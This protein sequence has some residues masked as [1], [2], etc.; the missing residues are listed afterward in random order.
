MTVF[1]N[2]LHG[3]S[4]EQANLV[5]AQIFSAN[6]WRVI[7]EMGRK[8][9]FFLLVWLC[10]RP[11]ANKD[12]VYARCR[13]VEAAPDGYLDLWGR[14]HFKSSIITFAGI[15]QEIMRNPEI[16]VGIFSHNN[17]TARK[18][19]NQIKREFEDNRRLKMAYPEILFEKPE[20][21]S[22]RW[23]EQGGIVVRRKGNPKEATVEAHGLIDGMPV[24]A[25]YRLQVY[26][27][28][29]TQDN[30][31]TFEQMQ[32]TVEAWELSTFL[33]M[34][35]SRVWYAGTRYH[36]A[37]A[38]RTI[39]DRGAAIE[40]CHP[41][42]VDGTMAGAPVLLSAEYLAKKRRDLGP[43][44]FSA[45]MLLNPVADEKQGFLAAWLRHWTPDAG[46]HLNRYIFVDPANEKKRYSDYTAAWVVGLGADRNYYV[47]DMVR[48]RLNLTQR[49]DML[50]ELHRK[51]KP[52][53]TGYEKYGKDSDI[54]HYEDR[55]AR[56]NYR[57]EILPLG[58]QTKKADRIRRLVPLFENKRIYLPNACH[59]QSDGRPADLV[60]SFINQEYLAFP[61]GSH[62][63]MLD[64]LARMLDPDFPL[65]WPDESAVWSR[66][67]KYPK[68]AIV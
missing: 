65:V 27:D 16:T 14:E 31:T 32:K 63:D 5:Y 30:V 11:D 8:D 18:F 58:G 49:A 52:L 20:R 50:F 53:A 59:K 67:L 3:L 4:R 15:V 64:G 36:F 24:G 41:A 60:Q 1:A 43:F 61:V 45:Q 25:H 33:G 29:V 9:R 19:L 46:T 6:D 12:W 17:I 66:P 35:G 42:T 51:W 40:R 10:D 34:D 62:D 55:M 37:D 39:L 23:S 68:R 13:E 47:L 28:V 2:P 44:V 38:Y 57:F 26:D 7:A 56:E 22:P 48:D 21:E 54:Q